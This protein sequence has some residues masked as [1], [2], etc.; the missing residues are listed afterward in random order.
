[1]AVRKNVQLLPEDENFLD[2]YGHPWETIK[3]GHPWVLIHDFPV[4][5]GYNCETVTVA[6]RLETGYP[7]S[8]LDMAY[9]HPALSRTDGKPIGQ[10]NCVQSLDGKQFQRWSRHRTAKNPWVPGTDNLESHVI[11]IEDWLDREFER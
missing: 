4:P 3:E 5:K 7:N 1:M 11:L 2:E 10:T 6:I 9:F 8:Q